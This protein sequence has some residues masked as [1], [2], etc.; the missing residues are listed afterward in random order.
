[1][2][3]LSTAS[4]Q[5]SLL[6]RALAI[7]PVNLAPAVTFAVYAIIVV[8]WKNQTLLAAKAFTS[9]S[10]IALLTTPVIIFI[11][12]LP[13]VIQCLKIFDRIQSFCE[14]NDA[15]DPS[16]VSIFTAD[17]NPDRVTAKTA[18]EG[19]PVLDEGTEMVSISHSV[20]AGKSCEDVPD[21]LWTR[22]LS[23]GFLAIIGPIGSG[24]SLLLARLVECLTSECHGSKKSQAHLGLP[25]AVAYC[26]HD[27]WLQARTIRQNIIGA[28]AFDELWYF[29]VR[30]ACALDTDLNTLKL[31]DLT[32]IGNGGMK[33]SGGQKQRIVS[34]ITI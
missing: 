10:L 33:L 26:A 1:M 29:K 32:K 21:A 31:G 28:S 19:Q 24:K 15:D 25:T 16:M 27:P 12:S 9:V 4:S 17:G 11:Q 13:L 18:E 23:G 30:S 2:R 22:C 34:C 20:S 8:L 14:D 5:Y 3:F 7:T 6:T